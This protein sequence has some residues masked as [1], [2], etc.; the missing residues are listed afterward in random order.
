ML[1]F[2]TS[3]AIIG[4]II[5]IA[6]FVK[7]IPAWISRKFVH[8]GVGFI[9]TKTEI[10]F[11]AKYIIYLV[12]VSLHLILTQYK[13][14]RFAVK[15]D[16]GIISYCHI[17]SFCIFFNIPIK[18]MAPLFYADPCGA[19]IG[20]NFPII[21]HYGGKTLSGSFAV[22]SAAYLTLTG[23]NRIY[24]AFIIAFLEGILGKWDNPGIGMFLILRHF[25]KL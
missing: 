16:K 15:N 19:I 18:E 13:F 2:Y 10:D 14:L 23:T 20:R 5:T 11:M 7:I 9:L 6:Q 21:K 25:L 3:F 1:S 8:I 24:S 12:G 22:F 17:L 4:L